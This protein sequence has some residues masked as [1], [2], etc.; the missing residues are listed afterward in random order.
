MKAI[1]NIIVFSIVLSAFTNCS[2][3]QKL[4][5]Q[6]PFKVGNVY[7]Q[8]WVAGVKGGGSGINIFIPIEN[9]LN[10]TIQLDSVYFRGRASKLEFKTINPS[11]FIGRFL[12]ST[13]QSKELIMSD[14]PHAEYGNKPPEP[15]SEIPFKLNPNECVISYIEDDKTLYYK[16]ENVAEKRAIPYPSTP[17][18]KQ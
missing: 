3:A 2:S 16:I 13:N 14:T 15:L 7:C 18:N 4:E 17:L 9:S 11:L 10:K 12:S 5:K 8:S 1:S 6:V